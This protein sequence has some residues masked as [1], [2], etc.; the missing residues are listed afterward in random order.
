MKILLVPN[1]PGWA[2][3]NRAKDLM[4]LKW[5]GI[6]FDL[7]YQCEIKS[8]DH[9]NYD[10]IYPLSLTIARKLNRGGVP[11][12]KMATGI[13]SIRVY[14]KHMID[15]GMF[16]PEFLQFIN[17]MR[18]INAWSDEI[19]RTF[20]LHTP[21]FKTRIGIDTNVFKPRRRRKQDSDTFKVG[22]V[23]R[24]DDAKHRELKGY[25][26][27]LKAL[28]GL[29]AKLEI[30]TF[31]EH[32]VPRVKMVDF[33]QDIDCFICSSRSEGLPNP[34]LEAGACGVPIITT[35]VGII[36]ELIQHK[37]NGIIIPR[38]SEAMRKQVEYLMKHPAE[39]EKL[40]GNIRETIV[41]NWTW[42]ICK[43]DWEA[44]FKSVV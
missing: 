25:D 2:F 33:Y 39:R 8:I 27:V 21:I 32:Y 13:T 30:R 36:P 40:G 37:K 12:N 28:K 43:K 9:K 22:W 10:L 17:K 14:E 41:N 26:L 19:V 38:T 4:A 24:I 20:K 3:D 7:K 18:G 5:K 15:K 44:F 35:K 11:F 23:G 6:R 16:K 42:D 34:V 29:D 31:K 1:D